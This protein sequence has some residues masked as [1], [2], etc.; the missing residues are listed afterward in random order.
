M[1]KLEINHKWISANEYAKQTGL[2]AEKVKQFI[3]AGKIEGEQTEDGYWKV[4]VYKDDAVSREVYE[5]EK[6]RR[7]ELETTVNVMKK[8]LKEV[9][10]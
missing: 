9:T 5:N 7:I 8:I 10:P 4:K 2:G 3:R 6:A 1:E